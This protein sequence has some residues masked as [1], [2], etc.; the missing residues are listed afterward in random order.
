MVPTWYSGWP[1]SAKEQLAAALD[2][3]K[4]PGTLPEVLDFFKGFFDTQSEPHALFNHARYR[5]FDRGE[6]TRMTPA[7]AIAAHF[8]TSDYSLQFIDAYIYGER[9]KHVEAD[10]RTITRFWRPQPSPST[11]DDIEMSGVQSCDR[12]PLSAVRTKRAE[13]VLRELGEFIH[14]Q[15]CDAGDSWVGETA[16]CVRGLDLERR[17]T[18]YLAGQCSL[19]CINRRIVGDHDSREASSMEELS[20]QWLVG[21]IAI[22]HE[23]IH[24]LGISRK[25]AWEI[26]NVPEMRFESDEF[27]ELGYAWENFVIGGSIGHGPALLWGNCVELRTIPHPL[28][29]A[30]SN[31]KEQCGERYPYIPAYATGE[32]IWLV[33]KSYVHHFTELIKGN[34]GLGTMSTLV[35]RVVSEEIDHP[36][37]YSSLAS[38]PM[39]ALPVDDEM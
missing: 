6:F 29:Q 14:F 35:E 23:I 22:A 15:L 7:F 36:T 28:W 16:A 10:G 9:T 30:A 4:G 26:R 19:I 8:L 25:S 18:R 39:P 34:K 11:H 3:V 17:E 24:S 2:A 33:G 31:T 27:G 21:G 32:V 12:R 13:A 37:L 5:G 20:R 38:P 1:G